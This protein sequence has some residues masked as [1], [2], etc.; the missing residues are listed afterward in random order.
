MLEYGVVFSQHTSRTAH[1]PRLFSL[2]KVMRNKMGE[3]SSNIVQQ[4]YT[5]PSQGSTTPVVVLSANTSLAA[6]SQ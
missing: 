2:T 5:S 1:Y 6:V 3:V 4:K